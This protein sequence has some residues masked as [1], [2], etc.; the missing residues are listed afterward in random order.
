MAV[1]KENQKY[2]AAQKNKQKRRKQLERKLTSG[3]IPE[4]KYTPPLV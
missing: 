4:K 3:H 1:E 2:K